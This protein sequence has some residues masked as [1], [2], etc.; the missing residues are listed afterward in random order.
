MSE[1]YL[2]NRLQRTIKALKKVLKMS[3][4]ENYILHSCDHVKIAE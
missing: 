1:N 4:P 3:M 2:Q